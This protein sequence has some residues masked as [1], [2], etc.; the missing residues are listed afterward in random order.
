MNKIVERVLHWFFPKRCALCGD[1]IGLDE[2]LCPECMKNSRIIPPL[3]DKCGRDK[4]RCECDKAHDTPDYA[5]TVAPFYYEGNAVKAVHRFKF[6]NRAE[7]AEGMSREMVGTVLREYDN[8]KF[9]Y[10]VYIPM[11]KKREKRRGYNQSLLLARC[12]SEKIGVPVLDAFYKAYENPPQRN[13]TARM[14]RANIFGA[15]DVYDDLNVKDKT[16]L[17]VDDVKTTG[18]TLS[19]CAAVLKSY[20]AKECCCVSFAIR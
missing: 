18:S 16:F 10:V 15:F 6:S 20:G 2:N 7:L 12:I 14:R 11:S 3:C 19:E 9:D 13:Q 1:V 17:I 4:K 8:I 5:K